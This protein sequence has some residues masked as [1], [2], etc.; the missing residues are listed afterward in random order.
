MRLS[1]AF[2][3]AVPCDSDAAEG[4]FNA[5]C[6]LE[7]CS[8]REMCLVSSTGCSMRVSFPCGVI[9]CG[10]GAFE[11]MLSAGHGPSQ[12]KG[13]QLDHVGTHVGTVSVGGSRFEQPVKCWRA[14]FGIGEGL[15]GQMWGFVLVDRAP[16]QAVLVVSASFS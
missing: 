9:Q 3:G 12:A 11:D 10:R 8:V 14:Q 7:V 5:M 2:V 16:S 1:G 6:A 4:L 13:G 15:W